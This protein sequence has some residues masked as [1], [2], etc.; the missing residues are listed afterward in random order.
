[1][2]V[3]EFVFGDE[4]FHSQRVMTD[5]QPVLRNAPCT[6]RSVAFNENQLNP[7]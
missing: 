5:A 7:Q 6:R 4:T 3:T 1:M 2:W